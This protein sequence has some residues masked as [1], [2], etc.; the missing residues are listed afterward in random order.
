MPLKVKCPDGHELTVPK[1]RAGSHVRCPICMQT[2][3]I[4]NDVPAKPAATKKEQPKP[5]RQP[6]R[7][8]RPSENAD[9]AKLRESK[10]PE[11]S[12]EASSSQ[13]KAAKPSPVSQERQ[14]PKK[15]TPEER[16][17]IVVSGAEIASKTVKPEP[18]TRKVSAPPKTSEKPKPEANRVG[19][20]AKRTSKNGEIQQPPPSAP[21]EKSSAQSQ[22]AGVEHDA[23]KRWTAYYLAG[24]LAV[25]GVLSIGPAIFE[26]VNSQN[27]VDPRPI[28]RWAYAALFVGGVQLFYAIYLVQLPD[29][30]SV[31]VVAV[32]ALLIATGYAML[33]G[34]VWL[35][36]DDSHII[37][38]LGLP[39]HLRDEARLWCFTMLS[40]SGLLAYFSGREGVRWYKIH[41]IQSVT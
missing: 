12:R 5:N 23:A 34:I 1:Q 17:P 2:V 20:Q 27:P 21:I 22:V 40:A 35:G 10:K 8:A 6:T 33:L 14:T 28:E 30:S 11:P 18:A 37:N 7:Q 32:L 19:E 15:P 3:Q 36:K 26:F 38:L 41:T 24:S 9:A 16:K 31:W 13:R 25:I 4:P 39:Q 29:W